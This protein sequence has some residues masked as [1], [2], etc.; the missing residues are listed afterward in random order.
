ML[1]HWEH[2]HWLTTCW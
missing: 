2:I 1:R